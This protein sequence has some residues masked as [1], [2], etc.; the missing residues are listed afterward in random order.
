M[1]EHFVGTIYNFNPPP[2]NIQVDVDIPFF[3]QAP[4]R[5]E[6]LIHLDPKEVLDTQS[7]Q[8]LDLQSIPEKDREIIK[9]NGTTVSG[10]RSIFEALRADLTA[11]YRLINWDLPT[12]PQ[13]Q[14]ILGLAWDHL[15]MEGE[16]KQPMSKAKVVN[17]TFNYGIKKNINTLV[18][19]DFTF[20][21]TQR[22]PPS[23]KAPNTPGEFTYAKY[24]DKELLNISIQEV[25]Q[26]MKHWFEYKIP[27]WLSV[28]NEIQ[29][30]VCYERGLRPGNYRIYANLIENDFLQDNLSIL[31]EYGIPS[32][33]LRKLEKLVPKNLSEDAVINY[34]KENNLHKSKVLIPY[35][36]IKLNDI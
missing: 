4:I 31:G 24:S 11:N 18:K 6:L 3:E 2:A 14:Y 19:D 30:L 22:K 34:I 8:F 33:A 5:D 23:K 28:M 21:R 32:S 17:M 10:Q 7:P 27:K 1:M 16:T 29:K 35:E 13:L 26:I 9:K 20:K 36:Q 15:M 12:Y 25:F